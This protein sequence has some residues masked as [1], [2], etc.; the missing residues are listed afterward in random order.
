MDTYKSSDKKWYIIN[1][2]RTPEYLLLHPHLVVLDKT[3][4]KSSYHQI[5][6]KSEI[7]R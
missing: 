5:R 7:T 1:L 2:P 6:G 4:I 3:C